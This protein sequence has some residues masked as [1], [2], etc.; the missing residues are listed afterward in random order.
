MGD[1]KLKIVKG[2]IKLIPIFLTEKDNPIIKPHS[3]P[4]WI[5]PKL[6]EGGK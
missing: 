4:K 6:K 1:F 3:Q 5:P 2:E